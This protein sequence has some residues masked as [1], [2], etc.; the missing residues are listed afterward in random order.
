MT[1]IFVS[2]TEVFSDAKMTGVSVPMIDGGLTRMPKCPC[3]V[4]QPPKN[5]LSPLQLLLN[6]AVPLP[7]EAIFRRQKIQE[8]GGGVP[9]QNSRDFIR[10]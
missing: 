5:E 1:E 10:M 2:G 3:V 4:K 9:P 8:G 6:E 7:R